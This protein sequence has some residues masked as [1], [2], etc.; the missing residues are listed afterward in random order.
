MA[1]YPEFPRGDHPVL[2]L[3]LFD[4][5]W[6][7][8]FAL[9]DGVVMFEVEIAVDGSM[10]EVRVL[11]D[12]PPTMDF[13]RKALQQWK[14]APAVAGGHLVDSK[15]VVAISFVTPVINS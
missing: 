8:H 6:P 1:G 10:H 5:G 12:I 4:P 9:R 3:L 2:P 7:I 15:I 11:R 13:A 14:F